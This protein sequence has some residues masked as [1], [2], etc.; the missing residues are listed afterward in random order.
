[1]NILKIDDEKGPGYGQGYIDGFKDCLDQFEK[2]MEQSQK[3][4]FRWSVAFIL[5][6]AAAGILPHVL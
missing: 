4:S 1:M 3:R 2:S 5:M 6:V